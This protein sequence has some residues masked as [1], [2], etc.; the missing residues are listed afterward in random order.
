MAYDLNAAYI[1]PSRGYL[2]ERGQSPAHRGQRADQSGFD[3]IATA[4]DDY[5]E[6]EHGTQSRPVR[7][8]QAQAQAHRGRT[9][10]EESR[11]REPSRPGE[12]R[13]GEVVHTG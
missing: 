9:G 10:R 7:D 11:K 1:P 4:H 3:S 8:K 5:L 2:A 13:L 6:Q 12:T